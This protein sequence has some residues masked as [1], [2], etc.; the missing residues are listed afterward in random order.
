MTAGSLKDGRPGAS[1]MAKIVYCCAPGGFCLSEKAIER[2]AIL[3]H[4]QVVEPYQIK[5]HDPLLVQVVEELGAAA[6]GPVGRLAIC[7]ISRGTRYRIAVGDGLEEMVIT[8][9]SRGWEV[10]P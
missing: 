3:G 5:R 2:L 6:N 8:A 4:P 7:E 9:G 1:G 10:A